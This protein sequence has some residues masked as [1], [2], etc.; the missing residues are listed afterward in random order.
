MLENLAL[1]GTGFAVVILVLASLWGACALMGW[2]F[3]R[4]ARKTTA[5]VPET[6][7]APGVPPHHLAAIAAAVAETLGPGH[8]IRRVAAPAH[9]VDG[10]PLEGRIE[11]FAAHR[12]RT[13]WGPTRPRPGARTPEIT[14]G[15]K[16]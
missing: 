14:K 11:T 16:P 9:L 8:R 6:P 13:G 4:T 12:V 2:G 5:A 1:I 15:P 3:T 7:V 10:W